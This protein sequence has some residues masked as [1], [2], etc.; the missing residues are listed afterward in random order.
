MALT[1]KRTI[2]DT[3]I[4]SEDLTITVPPPTGDNVLVTDQVTRTV[5]KD[6]GLSQSVTIIG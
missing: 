4:I 1:K 5:G 3:V 6:R 2:A